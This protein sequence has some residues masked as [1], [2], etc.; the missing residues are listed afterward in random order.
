MRGLTPAERSRLTGV[1]L[2]LS[3]DPHGEL[4]DEEYAMT[5]KLVE[6]GRVYMVEGIDDNGDVCDYFYATDA[7]RLALRLWPATAATPPTV[8]R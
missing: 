4:N 2:D 7:G 1:E 5:L 8:E 6:Q 3:A